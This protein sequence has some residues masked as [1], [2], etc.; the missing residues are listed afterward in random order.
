M[1]A[2]PN[3]AAAGAAAQNGQPAMPNGETKTKLLWF[4]ATANLE[5][6]SSREKVAHILDRCVECGIDGVAVGVKSP[7]G[8]AL[9]KSAVAPRMGNF[10]GRFQYPADY[11]LLQTVVEEAK[12]RQL[13]VYAMA[14]VFS[15]GRLSDKSGPAYTKFP[16]WQSVYYDINSDGHP[17][18]M[19]SEKS[20]K[21][22]FVFVNPVLAQVQQYELDVLKELAA[23]YDVD[24][25]V[26]DRCRFD[27][28]R[29]DFSKFSRE[30]FEKWLGRPVARWPQD[31]YELKLKPEATVE[32]AE[33]AGPKAG[34][35]Y[36]RVDGPLYKQW[37]EWRASVLGAFVR[38]AAETVHKAKPSADFGSVVG[39]WYPEYA[40][41]GANWASIRFDPSA[42]Y[43]WATPTYAQ[44]G[45]ADALSFLVPNCYGSTVWLKDAPPN[46]NQPWWTVQGGAQMAKTVVMGACPIY[47]G[48][49]VEE[50]RDRPD[51]FRQA[52]RAC[53][54]ETQ[55]IKVFDL[56]QIDDFGWWDI[57]KA[58]LKG[59]QTIASK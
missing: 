41:E 28:M 42:R 11:D 39:C 56:S 12:T 54:Q 57:L 30:A 10:M 45:Y 47:A 20:S 36:D 13:K 21:G 58:E 59:Q 43:P 50:F 7:C 27:G 15:E 6:L 18:L 32:Q 8:F 22:V 49:Y 4:D 16:G 26:I 55:G 1:G 29:A 19:S 48:V 5:R 35:L 46:D 34:E 2:K 24:G 38:K 37:L 40:D 9:Y 52:I 17:A 33:A 25:V 51:A 31:I 14:M 53:L 3:T 23:N 44:T